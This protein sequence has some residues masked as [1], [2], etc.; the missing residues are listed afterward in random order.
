M[1]IKAQI[2]IIKTFEENSRPTLNTV[3]NWIK[4]GDINGIFI[5]GAAYIDPDNFIVKKE[6]IKPSPKPKYNVI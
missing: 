1:L 2:W 6:E 5:R 4:S 3:K